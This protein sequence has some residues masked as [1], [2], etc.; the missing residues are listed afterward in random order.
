MIEFAEFEE[1]LKKGE[2]KNSYIFCGIDEGLMQENIKYLVN[3][4]VDKTFREL[5]YVQF[6]GSTVDIEAVINTCE[7]IPIMSDKKV[8]VVY[9]A[10]FLGEG[11]DRE[12]NKKYDRLVKYLDSVSNSCI[13][14]V[15]Y[16][17][18]NDREKP[19][20]KIKKLDK[21]STVVKFDK[22]KGAALEKKVKSL[23]EK[24]GIDIG[25]I[26]LKLFC[27]G[28]ENNMNIISNE[29]D[30]LCN[31][32]LDRQITK[33]DVSIMLPP[34]SDNDIFDLVDCISQ[35]KPEKALDI[36]N[37]LI[38]KGEKATFILFMIERQFN[39][40]FNLKLGIE[41][42]KNKDMLSKELKLNPYICEKM[43]AQSKRFSSKQLINALDCCLNTEE[44]LKS[45][46]ASGKTEME[47][48][49]IRTIT[50]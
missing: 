4:N 38:F 46:S 29:V 30:K 39:I 2:T 31:Y 44:T 20:N 49:I 16:V 5:N 13:L 24:R 19:S 41:S 9:R 3:K 40:L 11:E 23:F 43:I 14:I 27:D 12:D 42:G 10:K 21:K 50:A 6:D 26:E 7:T 45:S 8:V 37:E 32:T 48:L 1:K 28:L 34:K 33:E 18:E 25:K 22:L 15:Y 47:L 35:K 36:L 17:F